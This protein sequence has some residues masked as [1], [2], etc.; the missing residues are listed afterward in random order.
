MC[1]APVLQSRDVTKS[2]IITG[3]AAA[4][5]MGSILSKSALGR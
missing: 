4:F 5:S 3:D 2:F 1:R